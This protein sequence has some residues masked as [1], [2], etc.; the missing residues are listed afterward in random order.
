M[1]DTKQEIDRILPLALDDVVTCFKTPTNSLKL[2][3]GNLGFGEKIGKKER[4]IDRYEM[5]G[6]NG[7]LTPFDQPF[8]SLGVARL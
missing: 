4:K 7:F 3:L 5:D 8:P 6:S 1:K 2:I